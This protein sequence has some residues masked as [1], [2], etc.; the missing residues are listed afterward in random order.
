MGRKKKGEENV[1]VEIPPYYKGN[2]QGVSVY[3]AIEQLQILLRSL[4]F[5]LNWGLSQ[6]IEAG[7]TNQKRPSKIL[8]VDA[9]TPTTHLSVVE[10]CTNIVHCS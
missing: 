6:Y 3:A 1:R 4:D 7:S 8:A 10:Q 2:M 9:I 5:H